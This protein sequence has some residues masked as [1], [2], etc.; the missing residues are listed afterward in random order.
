MLEKGKGVVVVSSDLPEILS[1]SDRVYVFC[2]GEIVKE[3]RHEEITSR[4]LLECALGGL[5]HAAEG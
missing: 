2:E 4:A 5:E 3:F 1:I